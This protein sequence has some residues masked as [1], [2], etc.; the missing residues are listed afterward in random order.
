VDEGRKA[1]SERYLIDIDHTPVHVE[2]TARARAVAVAVVATYDR[3]AAITRRVCAALLAG[4][5][6]V[7]VTDLVSRAEEEELADAPLHPMVAVPR[8]ARVIDCF[9]SEA[10][11]ARLPFVVFEV[12]MGGASLVAS[13]GRPSVRAVASWGTP[14]VCPDDLGGLLASVVL[15]IAQNDGDAAFRAQSCLACLPADNR[16]VLVA[17][18]TGD[19]ACA[20]ARATTTW[21]LQRIAD[22]CRFAGAVL[23]APA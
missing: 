9:A 23:A 6:S 10:R 18:H 14:M 8:L 13:R 7:V 12:G 16:L 19:A 17:E 3:R 2:V 22:E 5:F 21:L 15:L 20:V 1:V 4:G 11:F